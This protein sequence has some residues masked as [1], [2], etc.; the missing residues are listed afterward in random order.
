MLLLLLYDYGH[1]VRHC[2]NVDEGVCGRCVFHQVHEL[3]V[4]YIFMV[5]IV[6]VCIDII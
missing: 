2:V 1:N 5:E 4:E 6:T 3:V